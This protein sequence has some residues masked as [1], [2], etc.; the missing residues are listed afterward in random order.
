VSFAA[1][2]GFSM[3]FNTVIPAQMYI[4]KILLNGTFFTLFFTGLILLIDSQ[5]KKDVTEMLNRVFKINFNKNVVP[6]KE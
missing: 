6:N 3:L 1:G 2:W 5:L 4:I